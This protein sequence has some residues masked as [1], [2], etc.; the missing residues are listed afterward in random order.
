MRKSAQIIMGA[1][2]LG[3]VVTGVQ[4]GSTAKSNE[5]LPSPVPT[6]TPTDSASPSPSDSPS[7]NPKPTT[8]KKPTQTPTPKP[9]ATVSHTSDPIYYRYGVV[10]VTVVKKGTKITDIQLDQATATNGRSAAFSYLVQVALSAQG[11]NFDQSLLSGA[12][13]TT[14]A[15][16]QAMDSALN[17]F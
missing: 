17:Q 2:T 9:V 13:F 4:L 8:T 14:D 15:F 1:L 3:S 12:T 6:D 7:A 16:V 11:S 5:F 10:Q